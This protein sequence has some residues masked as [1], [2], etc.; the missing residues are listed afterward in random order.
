[1][2]L[3]ELDVLIAQALGLTL[4]ELLLIY[5]VQFPVMQQNER[6]TWY[7]AHGR[8]AFTSSKGLVGVGLPRK[9]ARNTPEVTLTFPDGR[10][11]K[12]GFGWEDVRDVP[13]G[14]AV[15]V[16]VSDDTLPGGPH[17]RERR[18]VAPFATANREEDYRI[19]WEFFA[20]QPKPTGAA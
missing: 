14:T 15:S 5:R 18:W 4:E 3:V 17:Q 12:G 13:D 16:T 6:D 11:K 7:D 8:I 10:I 20:N 9:A 2:A 19:A 1:M